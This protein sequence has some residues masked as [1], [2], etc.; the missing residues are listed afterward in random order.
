[1]INEPKDLIDLIEK[2]ERRAKRKTVFYSIIPI[3]L[4]VILLIY[5]GNKITQLNEIKQERERYIKDIDSMKVQINE[6]QKQLEN[7][8][9]FISNVHQINW[10][11]VKITFSRYPKQA[12]ILNEIMSM[13]DRNVK[14]KIGSI[15]PAKGFDSPSFAAFMINKYSRT[16]VNEKERYKLMAEV[17]KAHEPKIGDLIFYEWGYAMFYFKD[18]ANRPFCIGM[19]PAGI[20]SLNVNFG[21]KILGYGEIDY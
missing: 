15:D 14:W 10:S 9:N 7:S 18:E 16:R 21:P 8:T 13:K 4:A 20:V 3:A 2:K 6:L 19:T 12:M 1:M 11:T 5:S 17:P